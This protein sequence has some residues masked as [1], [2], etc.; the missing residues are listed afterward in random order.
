MRTAW[1]ARLAALLLALV[2]TAAPA[3]TTAPMAGFPPAGTMN[4][5]IKRDGDQI[6]THQMQFRRDGDRFEVLT[7]IEVAVKVLG[8]TAFRFENQSTEEWVDGR[9]ASFVSRSNDDGKMHDVLVRP[10]GDDAL[11]VTE[12]GVRKL[13]PNVSLIGTLWNPA[14]ASQ[15]RLI[16]PVDGKLR[17][18]AIT[19]HGNETITVRGEPVTARHI[20]IVGK[21]WHRE[22]WYGPDGSILHFEFTAKDDSLIVAELR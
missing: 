13:F 6:G 1:P 21:T 17:Q 9:L 15:T 2:A 22:V 14:T 16:D 12:N 3:A 18:V 7:R 8:I 4:Y 20:T 10:Q 11:W 19:D 5:V